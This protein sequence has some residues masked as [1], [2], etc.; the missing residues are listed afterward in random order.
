MNCKFFCRLVCSVILFVSWQD[1]LEELEKKK[2]EN[3][4]KLK[5]LGKDVKDLEPKHTELKKLKEEKKKQ[6]RA[7]SVSNLIY[8]LQIFFVN[9]K[10]QRNE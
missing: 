1:S 5:Q 4:N 3:E 7:V 2:T 6:W 10:Q 9:N 8:V